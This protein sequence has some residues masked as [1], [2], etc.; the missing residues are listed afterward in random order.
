MKCSVRCAD[1]SVRRKV[2]ETR[3]LKKKVEM[4]DISSN[5]E[6]CPMCGVPLQSFLG[7]CPACGEDLD[8][9][10]IEAKQLQVDRWI[11][12]TGNVIVFFGLCATVTGTVL[13]I[14]VPQPSVQEGLSSLLIFIMGMCWLSGGLHYRLGY[15]RGVWFIQ[16]MN[17]IVSL[18]AFL[19]TISGV[20]WGIPLMVLAICFIWP[21]HRTWRELRE[22]KAMILRRSY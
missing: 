3:R 10:R 21:A 13:I 14:F 9:F 17:A 19:M 8:L 15:E 22:L 4:V 12:L 5:S 6:V 16:P 20:Y 18:I 1:R 7:R 11:R 2:A